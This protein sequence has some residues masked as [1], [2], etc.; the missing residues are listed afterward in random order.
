MR[1]WTPKM[2]DFLGFGFAGAGDSRKAWKLPGV[3]GTR[4]CRWK[5]DSGQGISSTWS[6]LDGCGPP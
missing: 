2:L 3:L 5:K 4:Q 1:D 6:C